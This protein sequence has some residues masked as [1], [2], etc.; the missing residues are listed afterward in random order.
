MSSH[1]VANFRN[2]LSQD[3]DFKPASIFAYQKIAPKLFELEFLIGFTVQ[4][5]DSIDRAIRE[6]MVAKAFFQGSTLTK[7]R[8]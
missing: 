1:H 6:G 7:N 5:S 2:Q 3:P 8:P 4:L